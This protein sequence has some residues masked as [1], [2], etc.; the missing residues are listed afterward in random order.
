M[1]NIWVNVELKKEIIVGGMETL[2]C[3][4]IFDIHKDVFDTSDDYVGCQ[5]KRASF[6]KTVNIWQEWIKWTRKTSCNTE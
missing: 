5:L 6:I 3:T 1:S 4:T 2:E